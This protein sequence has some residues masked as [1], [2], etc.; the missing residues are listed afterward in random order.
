MSA[1]FTPSALLALCLLA[2]ACCTTP[3]SAEEILDL[4]FRTPETTLRTFQA[5]VRGDY[6]RLEYRCFSVAFRARSVPPL[7]QF[8]YRTFRE[9]E[10]A[11]HLWFSVGVPDAEI[12]ESIAL[13][14]R[15]HRIVAR[16][17][18]HEF[19]LEL[20][21]ED[22]WQLWAGDELLVDLPFTGESFSEW[23]RLRSTDRGVALKL[24]ADVLLSDVLLD[25]EYA[26]WPPGELQQELTELRLI[27]E[28]KID[29]IGGL[30][31]PPD[32]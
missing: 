3:P 18:G 16:S 11:P 32:N 31:S 10:L 30:G 9:R 2:P 29:S 19:E 28:W 7:S 12:V 25:E 15:R 4:G 27:R 23:L 17:H 13:S 1:R 8:L 20:V 21:R 6:P 26:Y 24:S 22:L 14:A 5:G